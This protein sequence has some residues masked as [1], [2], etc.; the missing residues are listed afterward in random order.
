[1]ITVSKTAPVTAKY[2]PR[3]AASRL[4]RIGRICRPMKMKARMFSANTTV[5]HTA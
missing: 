5:S 3:S 1:M 2:R 4:S